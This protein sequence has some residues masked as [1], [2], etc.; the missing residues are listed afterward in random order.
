M[1]VVYEQSNK[2]KAFISNIESKSKR[3]GIKQE[4][5]VH[6]L[7]ETSDESAAQEGFSE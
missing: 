6:Y 5:N 3:N 1:Q 7:G 4:E 2:P